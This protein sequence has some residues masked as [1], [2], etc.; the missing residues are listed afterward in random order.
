M[1]L[2][3]KLIFQSALFTL[4]I[5]LICVS[6]SAQQDKSQRPSPP[7]QVSDSINNMLITIDYSQ[8]AV[9]GRKIWDGLVPYGKVWRTG[10][11]EASWIEIT[12]DVTIDGNTLSK[13]K[14][15]LFTI[16]GEDEWTII[17]NKVWNQWGAYKYDEAEDALRIK[18]PT[19][20][21]DDFNER[22]TISI[23]DGGQV[24]LAWEAIQ[25]AFTV[26]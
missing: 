2:T 10:A 9:K 23:L 15:G 1:R 13:G 12:N 6:A 14:Y 3:Q 17:F 25:V 19:E 8:P 11:N 7:A 20:K 5:T 26:E 21:S 18:V 22:F 24:V 16:P 4:L